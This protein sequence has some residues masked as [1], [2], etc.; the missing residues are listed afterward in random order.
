MNPELGFAIAA[1]IL[2]PIIGIAHS[3][4]AKSFQLATLYPGNDVN[5]RI[6]GLIW[7]IPSLTWASLGLA[8]LAARLLDQASLP[9]SL[10][11]I[12]VY[13]LSGAGNL[14]AVRKPFIGG[15]LLL[16]TGLCALMDWLVFA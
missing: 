16:L 5:R 1:A 4:F 11:A 8:I 9:L 2:G 14:W 13:G 3:S 15:F 7:H 6:I 10:V 12:T